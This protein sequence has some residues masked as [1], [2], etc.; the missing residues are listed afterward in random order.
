VWEFVPLGALLSS[1]ALDVSEATN[2]TPKVL[3]FSGHTTDIQVSGALT[4]S[5]SRC[6]C[7]TR[8]SMDDGRGTRTRGTQGSTHEALCAFSGKGIGALTSEKPIGSLLI[9]NPVSSPP[10]GMYVRATYT[11]SIEGQAAVGTPLRGARGPWRVSMR[12]GD[13]V[14]WPAAGADLEHLEHDF[15]WI[16]CAIF[17]LCPRSPAVHRSTGQKRMYCRMS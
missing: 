4:Q 14:R 7:Y 10:P 11:E 5:V 6:Q 12:G 9:A 8:P 16:F 2:C 15:F 13:G 1:P 3:Q 17:H